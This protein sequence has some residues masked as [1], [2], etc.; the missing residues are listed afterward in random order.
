[1][2]EDGAL[3]LKQHLVTSATS[4]NICLCVVVHERERKRPIRLCNEI[5]NRP[6]GINLDVR[7]GM[8]GD[9]RPRARVNERALPSIHC[10][11]TMDS[12]LARIRVDKQNRDQHGSTHITSLACLCSAYFLL[13]V[14]ILLSNIFRHSPW[15]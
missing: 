5:K 2:S 13:F 4:I 1:M 6:G 14:P 7:D 3:T 10:C 11:G 9:G 8:S 15:F 12:F